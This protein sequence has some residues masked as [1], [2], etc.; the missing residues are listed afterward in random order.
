[1]SGADRVKQAAAACDEEG[2]KRDDG[3]WVDPLE[4]QKV[5]VEEGFRVAADDPDFDVWTIVNPDVALREG[6]TVAENFERVFDQW[7]GTAEKSLDE[8]AIRDRLAQ[9]EQDSG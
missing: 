4:V 8:S 7:A 3:R 1:M 5:A 9:L 6:S 2:Y